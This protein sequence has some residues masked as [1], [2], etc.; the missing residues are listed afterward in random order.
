MPNGRQVGAQ[1]GMRLERGAREV[2]PADDHVTDGESNVP[3]AA[4]EQWRLHRETLRV[5]AFDS[6]D[7]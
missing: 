5:A 7:K 2:L 6:N 4:V 3:V 1:C